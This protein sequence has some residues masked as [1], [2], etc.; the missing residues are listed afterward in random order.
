[1]N[2]GKIEFIQ[3]WFSENES[4]SLSFN[5]DGHTKRWYVVAQSNSGAAGFSTRALGLTFD[6]IDAA[7]EFVRQA[8][9]NDQRYFARLLSRPGP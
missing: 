9:L 6:D 3:R 7:R 5:L 8:P 4:Y 2:S 1:M